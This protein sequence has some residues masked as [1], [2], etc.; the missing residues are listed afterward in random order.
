MGYQ[1][2]KGYR[3]NPMLR[4][5][6]NTICPFCKSGKK[7]KKCCLPKAPPVLTVKAAREMEKTLKLVGVSSPETKMTLEG[8]DEEGNLISEKM[9]L[10]GTDP[11][12]SEKFYSSVRHKINKRKYLT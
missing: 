4:V 5:G 7:F 9:V 1:A 6:R 11:I 2:L 3:Y 12:T 8:F 10:K